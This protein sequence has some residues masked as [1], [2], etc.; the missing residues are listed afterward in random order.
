MVCRAVSTALAA[1]PSKAF[2]TALRRSLFETFGSWCEEGFMPG[3]Y[4]AE[5]AKAVHMSRVRIKDPETAKQTEA[6]LA[7]ASD[8]VE[9]AAYLAMAAMLLVCLLPALYLHQ[10][11]CTSTPCEPT[12]FAAAQHCTA[13][14]YK[15]FAFFAGL[16]CKHLNFLAVLMFCLRN[17]DRLLSSILYRIYDIW[18]LQLKIQQSMSRVAEW[19]KANQGKFVSHNSNNQQR[20]LSPLTAGSFL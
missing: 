2:S 10:V 3:R 15:A 11:L 16:C 1:T 17:I 18:M 19:D 8:V 12:V 9:H 13:Q 4:R 6:E 14:S 5:V 7:E 20:K